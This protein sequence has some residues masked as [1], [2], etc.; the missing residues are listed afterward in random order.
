MIGPNGAGKTTLFRMITGQEQP[1]SGSL[2]IGETVKLG[3]VDQSRDSSNPTRAFG[4][5]SAEARK[6]STSASGGAVTRL[7]GRVQLQGIGSTKK[8]GILSGGNVTVCIS[9]KC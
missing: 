6:S 1:D 9:R 5:R 3:Y 4:R 7:R 2:R 8:V